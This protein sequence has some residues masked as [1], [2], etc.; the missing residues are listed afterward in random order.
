MLIG[1]AIAEAEGVEGVTGALT[2]AGSVIPGVPDKPVYIH[3]VVDGEPS[4]AD[5]WG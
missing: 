2:Y 4:L 1:A 3:Q 5:T